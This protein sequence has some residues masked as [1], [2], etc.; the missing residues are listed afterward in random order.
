LKL[1]EVNEEIHGIENKISDT[2]DRLNVLFD[3]KIEYENKQSNAKLDDINDEIEIL[4][5]KLSNL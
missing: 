3:K 5:N 4:K 2:I 1:E